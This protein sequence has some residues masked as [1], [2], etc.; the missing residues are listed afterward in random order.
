MAEV[1]NEVKAFLSLR[2]QYFTAQMFH[3]Q[4]LSPLKTDNKML[5]H[6]C[7]CRASLFACWGWGWWKV[8]TK[9]CWLSVLALEISGVLLIKTGGNPGNANLIKKF[10]K[11]SLNIRHSGFMGI[12]PMVSERQKASVTSDPG[13][14]SPRYSKVGCMCTIVLGFKEN[15]PQHSFVVL[16]TRSSCV[17]F[18]VCLLKSGCNPIIKPFYNYL[19]L[20]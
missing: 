15:F 13:S 1:K 6:A 19:F 14:L 16:S 11:N 17:Y 9:S 2:F 8:C 10:A 5:C 4:P 3:V 7:N 18:R 12:N 20:H